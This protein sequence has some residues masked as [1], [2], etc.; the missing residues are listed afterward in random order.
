MASPKNLSLINLVVVSVG[1]IIVILLL[2]MFRR[3]QR[4]EQDI[5]L[6][7]R[8]MDHNIKGEDIDDA[9]Q[10]YFDNNLSHVVQQCDTQLQAHYEE[11]IQ[12][13]E[14]LLKQQQQL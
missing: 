9:I 10:Y 13:I 1:I 3:L 5:V 6:T 12:K 11:P 8:Q 4:T 2:V 14:I 7:R